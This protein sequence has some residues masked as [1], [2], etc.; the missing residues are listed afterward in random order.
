MKKKKQEE[1]ER[2][3]LSTTNI[4]AYHPL[5][6]LGELPSQAEK[7]TM[8]FGDII[9]LISYV[10]PFIS[11]IWSSGV[12]IRRQ[13]ERDMNTQDQGSHVFTKEFTCT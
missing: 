11:I 3:R 10:E 2:E 9:A 4:P 8:V 13:E 1:N 5:V 12:I 6:F 7:G